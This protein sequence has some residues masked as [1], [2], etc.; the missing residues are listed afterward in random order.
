MKPGCGLLQLAALWVGLVP[1]RADPPPP[2]TN[3][4][5]PPTRGRPLA[6]FNPTTPEEAAMLA[7]TRLAGANS[8]LLEVGYTHVGSG[9]HSAGVVAQ[10][11]LWMPYV[12]LPGIQVANM[13]SIVILDV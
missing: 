13:G 6:A 10:L 8:L 4:A 11:G 9:G 3:G 5:A 1:A 7:L 2:A 12:F